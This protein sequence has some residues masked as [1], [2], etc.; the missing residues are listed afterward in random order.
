MFMVFDKDNAAQKRETLKQIF[1]D[2]FNTLGAN[3]I[4]S[5]S[6]QTLDLDLRLAKK[7]SL[8]KISMKSFF[9]NYSKKI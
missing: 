1:I 5:L 4:Q 7:A 8:F 6:K 2:C 9:L 3:L